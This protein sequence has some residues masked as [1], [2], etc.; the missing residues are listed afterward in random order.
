MKKF[1]N[2]IY[3][4]ILEFDV[5]TVL[6]YLTEAGQIGPKPNRPKVKSA[7]SQIGPSQIGLKSNRPQVK[8]A[9][10]KSAPSQIGLKSNRPQVKS[11][12]VKS[13]PVKSAPSQIGPIFVV[14]YILS[15]C[16]VK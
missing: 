6:S 15:T 13:A 14:Y 9:P 3:V 5:Q 10:V 1:Y 2:K 11:A 16:K 4:V 8:S 12:P 7:P